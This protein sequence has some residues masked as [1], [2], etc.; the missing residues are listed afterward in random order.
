MHANVL[1]IFLN[2]W[3]IFMFGREV[4]QELGARRMLLL[5]FLSGVAGGAL[6]MLGTWLLPGLMDNVP[7]VGASAGA[8]GLVAAFGALFPNEILYMLLFFVIPMKMRASTLLWISVILALIGIIYPFIG[9]FVPVWLGINLLFENIGHAAHLGGI[10]AGY[11][12]ARWLM[13]VRPCGAISQ[14]IFL[15]YVENSPLTGLDWK[16]YVGRQGQ[17][18]PRPAV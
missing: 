2:S 13:P 15:K 7:V 18:V 9:P 6:Q 8:F 14:S 17:Y 16:L 5:Y 12:F 3:A 10:L 4:E 1:H 11:I